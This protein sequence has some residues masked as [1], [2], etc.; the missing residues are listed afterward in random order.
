MDRA[1]STRS[2]RS[3]E[4]IAPAPGG[5]FT[6]ARGTH[7]LA[8]CGDDRPMA[9]PQRW[10]PRA[11]NARN[12]FP[13]PTGATLAKGVRSLVKCER[14]DHLCNNNTTPAIGVVRATAPTTRHHTPRPR[15]P[16][17][18]KAPSCEWSGEPNVASWNQIAAWLG[19]LDGLRGTPMNQRDPWSDMP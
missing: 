2:D 12:A 19:R 13:A 11:E 7:W 16:A 8:S 9:R 18:F 5:P 6:I 4:D 14:T 1:G 15:P 3:R 17:N 10:T